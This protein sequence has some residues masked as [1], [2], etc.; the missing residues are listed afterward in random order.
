MNKGPALRYALCDSFLKSLRKKQAPPKK[1]AQILGDT[2]NLEQF[3]W[4]EV[5]VGIRSKDCVLSPGPGPH[6][7]GRQAAIHSSSL[8]LRPNRCQQ[9]EQRVGRAQISVLSHMSSVT[10][11]KSLKPSET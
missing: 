3:G 9:T 8:P 10:F 4:P 2:S 5:R 7:W 11:G 1:H 6:S